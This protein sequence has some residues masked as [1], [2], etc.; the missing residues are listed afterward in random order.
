MFPC[1]KQ[2]GYSSKK[3]HTIKANTWNTGEDTSIKTVLP[4]WFSYLKNNEYPLIDERKSFDGDT[5]LTRSTI[6]PYLSKYGQLENLAT[7]DTTEECVFEDIG[8]RD[9]F[10]RKYIIE[11]CTYGMLRWSNG[12]FNPDTKVTKDV[13]LTILMRT[14]TWYLDENTT[15]WFKNYYEY[16]IEEGILDD[17]ISLQDLSW[18]VT[19]EEVG[20]RL[21][22]LSSK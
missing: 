21:Y 5:V 16:A 13:L 3:H 9:L 22:M 18:T 1:M 7:R 15:P 17:N 19:K 6:A 8:N 20:K 14:K 10:T 11:S 2:N 4:A 12:N